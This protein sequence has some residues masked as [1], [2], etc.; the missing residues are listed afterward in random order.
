LSEAGGPPI[1]SQLKFQSGNRGLRVE[2]IL[3]HRGNDMLECSGVVGQIVGRD[4]HA[5]SGQICRPCE[6]LTIG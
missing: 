3:R 4:R 2:R 1:T 5:R 6:R